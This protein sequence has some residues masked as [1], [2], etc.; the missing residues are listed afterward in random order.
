MSAFFGTA[1][2]SYCA[3][4]V[5]F[6]NRLSTS[7]TQARA[8][9]Y[10]VMIRALVNAGVW[11]KMDVLYM[12]AAA[13]RTTAKINLITNAYNCT[14]TNTPTFTAD[15]GFN[16]DGSTS[17]LDTNW[18]PSTQ[19]TTFLLNS[20]H[21]GAWVT[22][23]N[24]GASRTAGNTNASLLHRGASGSSSIKDN[25]ASATFLTTVAAGGHILQ[26]RADGSNQIPYNNGVAQA[27]GSV[28]SSSISNDTCHICGTPGGVYALPRVGVFHAGGLLTASEVAATYNAF[29]TYLQSIGAI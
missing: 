28:A 29:A 23:T 13:D 1:G 2:A 3:E 27:A 14:E 17:K 19:A 12:L 7:P 11:A 26:T 21:M 4:A 20:N 18:N 6:F 8:K 22:S 9:Q 24:T 15:S 25:A 5:A 10:D 16:G